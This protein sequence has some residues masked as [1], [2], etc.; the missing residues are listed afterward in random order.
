MASRDHLNPRLFDL[1]EEPDS[2]DLT[3]DWAGDTETLWHA[4]PDK[5]L[6]SKDTG[7]DAND[8]GDYDSEAPHPFGLH[9]GSSHAALTRSFDRLMHPVVLTGEEFSP[10]SLGYSDSVWDDNE[11]NGRNARL[12]K[13]VRAGRNIP[14]ENQYEDEGSISYR[15][16]VQ[17]VQTWAQSVAK[18]PS[19]HTYAERRAVRRGAELVYTPKIPYKEFGYRAATDLSRTPPKTRKLAPGIEASDLDIYPEG[20]QEVRRADRLIPKLVY[21]K[22][23][24]QGKEIPGQGKLL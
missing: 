10:M 24:T 6:P 7:V 12:T 20:E 23:S 14:Y 1:P 2:V 8:I 11:A 17:N 13:E 18:N 16:P 15:A 21:P 19:A 22:P 4:S 5:R 9:L 3:H